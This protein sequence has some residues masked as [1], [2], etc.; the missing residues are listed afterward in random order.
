VTEGFFAAVEQGDGAAACAR[1]S[2][3][4]RAQLESQE[5]RQCREA[6]TGL[7]LEGGAPTRIEVYETNAK[8]DLPGGQ[9]AFLSLTAQGWRLS[10]IGCEPE[11]GK[12]ADR[13]YDCE[14]E[15]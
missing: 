11:G 12:P 7:R 6:V 15:A 2:V 5:Q 3:D 9:S 1:L 4:T 8:A 13:P 10:A 14:I